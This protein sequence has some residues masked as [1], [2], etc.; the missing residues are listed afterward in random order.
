MSF[1]VSSSGSGTAQE[2][3]SDPRLDHPDP[4]QQRGS[5]SMLGDAGVL[6]TAPERGTK[7]KHSTEE[8]ENAGMRGRVLARLF[9][10]LTSVPKRSCSMYNL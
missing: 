10:I 8:R 5:F 6:Q 4:P 3:P 7:P 9:D 2:S 1:G